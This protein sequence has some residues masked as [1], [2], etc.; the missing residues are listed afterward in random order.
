MG[1]IYNISNEGCSGAELEGG[2]CEWGSGLRV[3]AKYRGVLAWGRVA[4]CILCMLVY[5][6]EVLARLYA[7][8]SQGQGGHPFVYSGVA[9]QQGESE[10][11]QQEEQRDGNKDHYFTSSQ[12]VDL[13]IPILHAC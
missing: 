3:W 7:A 11:G 12:R 13:S 4:I 5:L 1:T 9:G 6:V 8:H 2:Y 10:A